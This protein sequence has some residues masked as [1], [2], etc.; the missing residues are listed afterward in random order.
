MSEGKE[1]FN[2]CGS[3]WKHFKELVFF[4]QDY[5]TMKPKAAPE[6]LQKCS[7]LSKQSLQVFQSFPHNLNVT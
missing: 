3:V 7:R 1:R 5:V 2:G 6:E 4:Q